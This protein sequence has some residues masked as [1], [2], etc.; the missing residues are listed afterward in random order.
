MNGRQTE[1]AERLANKGI[2]MKTT[3]AFLCSAVLLAGC[4]KTTAPKSS[5]SGHPFHS[6]QQATDFQTGTSDAERDLQDGKLI[7]MQNPHV[8]KSLLSVREK[9]LFEKYGIT[10][11][12]P[13]LEPTGR[14]VYYSIGYNERVEKELLKKYGMN[15]SKILQSCDPPR[16]E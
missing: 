12:M 16:R 1:P 6:K 3:Y 5:S 9:T 14:G 11:L 7:L 15:I 8:G 13:Q 4:A 10:V 2:R